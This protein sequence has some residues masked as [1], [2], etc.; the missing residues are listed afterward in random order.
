MTEILQVDVVVIGAGISG[1]LAARILQSHGFSVKVLDKGR[2][3][4]GRMAT[5]RTDQGVFDHGAQFF[6][7]RDR[8]F[9]ALVE[10]WREAG[11]VQPWANG[12]ALPDGSSKNQDLTRYRGVSGM[13]AVP[14]HLAQDLDLQLRTRA[15]SV[16]SEAEGWT[17]N[18]EARE[19]IRCRALILT[20]PVPQSLQLLAAG[21]VAL[22]AQLRNSLEQ[23]D[24]APCLALLVDLP[25]ASRVPE[26]GGL[27]LSGEP[28]SWMADNQRKGVSSFP[29]AAVTIHAG[30]EFSRKHWDTSE[31]EVTKALLA[32]IEPWLGS[33]PV[34]TQL[35]RWRYS[36]PLRTYPER[37]LTVTDPAPLAFAG[38]AFGGPRVE[39]AALS[40]LAAGDKLAEILKHKERHVD[41]SGTERRAGAVWGSLIADAL[42]M[43]LHW[44]YDRDA[45]LRDYGE[46]S[47][48]VAPHNP[49][50]DSIHTG[51]NAAF[52]IT[53]S[54]KPVRTLS[55]FNLPACSSNRC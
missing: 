15:I 29:G 54:C 53:S 21:E 16:H 7:V 2:G 39:G 11:V 28:V 10:A 3:V 20:P 55:I 36:Q 35:H 31:P 6:T 43:P 52:T 40:G 47:N 23:I 13:T 34:R 1:L 8:R 33:N 51:A 46:V 17:V 48:Y 12:F 4:G 5:R 22:P 19:S 32:A 50:P 18:T 37:C 49:H 25:Q 38:D 9:G 27:W 45:M 41:P 14:K 30:P 44:Y 42:A 26:P 24:Y